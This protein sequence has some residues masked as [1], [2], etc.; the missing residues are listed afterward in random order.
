MFLKESVELSSFFTIVLR[1]FR[2]LIVA[3]RFSPGE[4]RKR[5]P[6]AGYILALHDDD[7]WLILISRFR[8][9]FGKGFLFDVQC[10]VVLFGE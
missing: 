2:L 5:T 1:C 3:V 10:V 9:F 7:I 8:P 4:P 6:T